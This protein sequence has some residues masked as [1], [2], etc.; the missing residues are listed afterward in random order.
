MVI[1]DV[2]CSGLGVIGKKPDIKYHVT[3]QS[4]EEVAAL[5]K[6]ILKNAAAYVK[7]GGILMYST[8]TINPEENEKQVEWICRTFPFTC[9][10]MGSSLPETLQKQAETGMVQLLPGVHETD[11]FFFARL[12]LQK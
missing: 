12:R 4:L 1:A 9:E 7:P 2:P 10:S 3:E 5:Q 11:G 8:C 6:E